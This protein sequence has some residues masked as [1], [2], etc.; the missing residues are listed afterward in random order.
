MQNS[1]KKK[2]EEL[3]SYPRGMQMPNWEIEKSAD[4]ALLVKSGL[5]SFIM[6]I[7]PTGL[8]TVN[9][10]SFAKALIK[11][12]RLAREKAMQWLRHDGCTE[13]LSVI[14]RMVDSGLISLST[15][16]GLEFVLNDLI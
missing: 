16:N 2:I 7:S 10:P 3:L 14:K 6:K 9:Y 1:T 15:E 5:V 4:L 13:P 11:D 8:C 12:G